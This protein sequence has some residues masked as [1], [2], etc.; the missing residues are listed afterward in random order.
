MGNMHTMIGNLAA[1]EPEKKVTLHQGYC[2]LRQ[3]VLT[4]M[5][6]THVAKRQEKV[7]MRYQSHAIGAD[8]A[9]STGG[10]SVKRRN[11]GIKMPPRCLQ[12]T[13][14]AIKLAIRWAILVGIKICLNLM[15]IYIKRISVIVSQG[16]PPKQ[17]EYDGS[18]S[19]E[20]DWES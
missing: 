19:V 15:H 5:S 17:L 6:L 3:T 16:V 11:N 1:S 4:A 12:V 10:T 13:P 14:H 7:R 2:S 8:N 20:R 9:V 18:E